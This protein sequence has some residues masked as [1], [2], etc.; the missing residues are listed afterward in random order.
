[1]AICSRAKANVD[2]ALEGLPSALGLVAD[3]S[4]AAAADM[5]G[6]VEGRLGPID[7]LVNSAGAARRTP[8]PD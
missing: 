7:V 1:V 8:P 2:R 3:C 6:Q 4:D 5:I